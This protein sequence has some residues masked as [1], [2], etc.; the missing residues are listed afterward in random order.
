MRVP[1]FNYGAMHAMH[2]GA[3]QTAI[4]DVLDRGA[5]ILQAENDQFESAL[6]D[7]VDAPHAIGV[8]NGTDAIMF[9]L[10][11]TGIG[12]GDEVVIPE[13]TWVASAS[14]VLYVGATPV[15]ADVDPV[16][17]CMTAESL[18][19]RITSVEKKDSQ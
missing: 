4:S 5:F 1:F 17:W 3:Y 6:A 13:L 8:A 11:A 16:T 18:E 9:A 15:F 7:F 10:R 19:R 12:P 14:P 2:A